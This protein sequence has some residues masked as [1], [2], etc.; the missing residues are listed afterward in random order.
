MKLSVI[1]PVYNVEQYIRPCVQSVYMQGLPEDDF[2][3]ILVND[4]TRDSSFEVIKDIISS[5][6]NIVV[7]EQSNQGLS[8]ARNLGL[9]RAS[10]QYVLFLDSDDLL[11]ENTLSYLLSLT[12]EDLVDLLIAGFVKM[13]NSEINLGRS[14]MPVEYVIEKKNASE[15][16][17]QDFNPRQCYVWRSIY[18]KRFLDENKLRFMPGIYF[19]DVPFT[20][21]CLIKAEKC[22]KTTLIFY[23]YRQRE[24]S[25]V[26]SISLKKIFD[27][28]TV[29]AKLWDMFINYPLPSQVRRQLM[30]TIF[31][32]FSIS[33]WYVS[34]NPLL[35]SQRKSIVSDLKCKVPNLYF[36]NDI[37]QKII[38]CIY[39]IAPCSYIKLRSMITIV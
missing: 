3:L 29:I 37:K 2:E 36:S 21:E 27:F 39:R 18:R 1:V 15:Y 13:D 23:V 6:N 9:L 14:I 31:A 25:I 24:N 19:E 32:T 12:N 17:L 11:I 7:L 26:S 16:F 5:H 34:S 22:I 28:N 10:G 20:T 8:A 30:N 4:G 33:V 35:L 38:S